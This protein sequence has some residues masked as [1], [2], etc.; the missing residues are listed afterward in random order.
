MHHVGTVQDR[1]TGPSPFIG[2]PVNRAKFVVTMTKGDGAERPV[3]PYRVKRKNDLATVMRPTAM[4]GRI[5]FADVLGGQ[6]RCAIRSQAERKNTPGSILR[7]RVPLVDTGEINLPAPGQ[8]GGTGR[9]EQAER[10]Q[11]TGDQGTG[12]HDE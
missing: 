7:G 9:N 6:R 5:F 8:Q 1:R 10:Q 3:W 4:L 11:R 12:K 2:I